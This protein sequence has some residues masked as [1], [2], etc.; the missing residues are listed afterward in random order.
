MKH[1]ILGT[2]GHVDHGKTALVKALTGIDCDTHKEEKRRGITINL[3]FAHCALPSGD[4]IGIIDVP[5]HRDFVHTMVSGA[6]GID[7]A[8]LVV[9]ADGGIM[10]Q[11]REHLQIMR[12][13]GI[14]TGIVALT[15]IDLVT[16][17]RA[18]AAAFEAREFVKGSFLETSPIVKVSSITGEG[19]GELKEKIGEAA[20]VAI[21]RPQREIFRLYIDRIFTVSGFG[22]IVTGS[23]LG[24]VLRTG[25]KAC[26]LPGGEEVRVRRIERYGEEVAEACAGD[27]ASLNLVGL[28]RE[29][30]VRGMMVADRP[31][32]TTTLIDARIEL[33]ESARDLPL[34]SDA[35][36]LLGTFEAQARIHLI[37]RE[38]LAPGGAAI[39]QLHLPSP[40]AAMHG[41]RFVLRATSGETT[42]G[43][44]A[45]IDAAPLHHRRRPAALVDHL[46]MLAGGGTAELV[47][48]EVRKRP[49]GIG[50]SR[51]ADRLNMTPQEVITALA[52]LP[53]DII[54][55]P[56][57]QDATTWLITAASLARLI[58]KC[59]DLLAAHHRAYPL[60][61]EG[62]TPEELQ[63]MLGLESGTDGLA[64]VR[65]ILDRLVA[66]GEVKPAGH[67]WALAAH[68]PA[69]PAHLAGPIAFVEE[70]LK[71]CGLQVP[72]MADLAAEARKRGIAE[73][74]LKQVL[75]FLIERKTVYFV[76]GNYIHESVVVPSRST[77]VAKLSAT[78]G[79]LTVAQFRDLIG[80]NRKLC[81]LLYVLFDA[82]GVTERQGDVRVITDK[83]RN[84]VLDGKKRSAVSGQ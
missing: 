70:F 31:L 6:S 25:A 17:E 22:C 28:S 37:D 42:L 9:A 68:A 27:R 35:L 11:T 59:K 5:G 38:T 41:D 51:I 36:F 3:G 76:E 57:L 48:V 15:R 43:G 40:C 30:F 78:P 80:A 61:T 73:A 19:I 4:T 39:V 64:L 33:F 10:P 49:A 75:R 60:L 18:A 52:S 34:W 74:T 24:G 29:D 26:L 50:H 77:L 66:A 32:R 2:A 7:I 82:E 14:R 13:L 46:S 20:A 63:G 84:A 79:G 55:L 71:K 45:V 21:D 8:L 23:A 12:L 69:V 1:L 62:K 56:P 72:I 44:G 58:D 47:A 81:L 67:T 53:G 65:R 83:G 54:A 16:P